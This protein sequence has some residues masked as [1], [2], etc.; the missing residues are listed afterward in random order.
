MNSE[1]YFETN[2]NKVSF[3][4]LKAHSTLIWMLDMALLKDL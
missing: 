3:T 2:L 4:S 1:L